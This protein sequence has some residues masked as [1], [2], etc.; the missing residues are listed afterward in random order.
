MKIYHNE[1]A[2]YE[3]KSAR[4]AY[5]ST[6][7]NDRR[8]CVRIHS[9]GRSD[10]VQKFKKGSGGSRNAK[11]WPSGIMKLNNFSRSLRFRIRNSVTQQ[12]DVN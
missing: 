3:T 7:V 1:A 12:S 6:T 9:A 4:S 8:S 11:I 10:F 2:V 5:A